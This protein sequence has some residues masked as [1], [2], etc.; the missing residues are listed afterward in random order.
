MNF[1]AGESDPDKPVI[2]VCRLGHQSR[3]QNF[4]NAHDFKLT[5]LTIEGILMHFRTQETI[6]RFMRIHPEQTDSI[7]GF[8][9]AERRKAT[10]S[11]LLADPSEAKTLESL[12]RVLQKHL[13]DNFKDKLFRLIGQNKVEN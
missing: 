5:P 8:S 4:A 11:R 2:S 9:A 13:G 3:I 12:L 7:R 1:L 6:D 10:I